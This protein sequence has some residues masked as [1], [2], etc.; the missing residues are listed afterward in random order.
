MKQETTP[1]NE[2]RSQQKPGRHRE[3]TKHQLPASAATI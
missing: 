3:D 2:T 1:K